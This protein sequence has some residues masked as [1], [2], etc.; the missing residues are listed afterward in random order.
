MTLGGSAVNYIGSGTYTPLLEGTASR[1]DTNAWTPTT[2]SSCGQ[3]IRIGNVV[4]VSG[5]FQLNVDNG[6]VGTIVAARI[7]LPFTGSTAFTDNCQLAGTAV[8]SC[9]LAYD[10]GTPIGY[11]LLYGQLYAETV[12]SGDRA[13][14]EME[15][16]FDDVSITPSGISISL[17][18]HFTYRLT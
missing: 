1:C 7:S 6:D 2:G 14:L 10:N 3:W 11:K 12:N 18:F 16:V 17:S 4:N 15:Q 5:Q 9:A 8:S 13:V